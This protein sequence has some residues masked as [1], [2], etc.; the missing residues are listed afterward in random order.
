[1]KEQNNFFAGKWRFNRR[2]AVA[3]LAMAAITLGSSQAF[4]SVICSSAPIE[5]ENSI[6]GIYLN[7][8]TGGS[9]VTA[10]I[11]GWDFNAYASNGTVASMNFFSSM[12]T[13]NTTRYLGTGA[14][15]DVLAGGTMIDATSHLIPAGISPGGAFQA[16]VT[17]GYLGVA[18]RN[19]GAAMTNYGWALLTTTGPNGFPATINQYCYQNDGS[20][21]MAGS[22]KIFENGFEEEAS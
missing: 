22:E 4:A 9:S 21:I 18:F 7:F 11:A 19:E 1:M 3:S 10:S 6:N 15:V 13:T 12:A 20:G 2:A 14:T 17:N 5:I 8:V 16:G